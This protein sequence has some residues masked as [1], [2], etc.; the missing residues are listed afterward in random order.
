[1]VM[2]AWRIT[3]A[4]DNDP[5]TKWPQSRREGVGVLGGTPFHPPGNSHSAAACRLPENELDLWVVQLDYLCFLGERFGLLLD[6][7]AVVDELPTG[8]TPVSVP[9]AIFANCS[10]VSSGLGSLMSYCLSCLTCLLVIFDTNVVL[11]STVGQA[12][13]MPNAPKPPGGPSRYIP[14]PSPSRFWRI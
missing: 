11:V 12:E 1:L 13:G 9:P 10:G 8:F 4:A 14:P 2:E 5:P 3:R 7:V 6:E